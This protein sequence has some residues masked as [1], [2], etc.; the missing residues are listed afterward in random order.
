MYQGEADACS[1]ATQL[2]GLEA[3]KAAYDLPT[4]PD[5]NILIRQNYPLNRQLDAAAGELVLHKI[6]DMGVKVFTGCEPKAIMT[7]ERDGEQVFAGFELSDGEKIE[8]D[9]V[10][11]TLLLESL[12]LPQVALARAGTLTPACP[13][14]SSTASASRPGTSSPRRRASR[15]PLEAASTLMTT[16]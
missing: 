14:R 13:S 4:L 3:A 5:V 7:V 2:L 11:P 8:S 6:E 9:L 1:S 16:S 10:R 15:S 12:Y